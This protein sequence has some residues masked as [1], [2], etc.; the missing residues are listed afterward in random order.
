MA[1][2]RI[3]DS[4]ANAGGTLQARADA[5]SFGA[6]VGRGLQRVG[7]GLQ[8]MEDRRQQELERAEVSD[9][10]SAGYQDDLN[11]EQLYEQEAQTAQPGDRAVGDRV[12]QKVKD[13]FSAKEDKYTT[14]RARDYAKQLADR[15]INQF[16][17]RG[18]GLQAALNG[19]KYKNDAVLTGD[20]VNQTVFANPDSY[21]STRDRL[22][23]EA[24][25]GLGFW[26]FAKPGDRP[27]VLES[28]T[29]SA[30]WNAGLGT[31]AKPGGVQQF[32]SKVAPGALE[33]KDWR[34]SLKTEKTGIPWFDDLDADKKIQ[35]ISKA[36]AD[37][38]QS[39]RLEAGNLKELRDNQLSELKLYGT[40]RSPLSRAQFNVYG[41]KADEEWRAYRGNLKSY[42]LAFDLVKLPRAEALARIESLKPR[43][44]DVNP[45]NLR[46]Y[47]MVGQAY[48]DLYEQL[49][50][51]QIGTAQA[52]QVPGISPIS[53]GD[54]L[55]THLQKLSLRAPAVR[56]LAANNGK[57]AWYSN[58]EADVMRQKLAGI[59]DNEIRQHFQAVRQIIKD[60]TEHRADPTQ[61][62]PNNP[63]MAASALLAGKN[64]ISTIDNGQVYDASLVSAR[65]MSGARYLDKKSEE[66]K[67]IRDSGLPDEDKMKKRFM[68]SV[69]DAV[70]PEYMDSA[71]AIAKA[72]YIGEGLA[73]RQGLS[74]G[75]IDQT[76]ME[77]A[78]NLTL[79]QISQNPDGTKVFAPW[80]M[81]PARFRNE[82][83][84]R[85]DAL[86]A[87][88][89]V[90]GGFDS[91]SLVP[92]PGREGVYGI[93]AGSSILPVVIDLNQPVAK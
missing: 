59:G 28:M 35:L 32:L 91:Q 42:G 38:Q 67:S 54:D 60:P 52:R 24:Q 80:G 9:A 6:D 84:M 37:Y 1:Q 44:G 20:A 14:P 61:L 71:Y 46:Q 3:Y 19:Q 53:S 50:R 8:R 11:L 57:T 47:Q 74:G 12:L 2:I 85:Y 76:Q 33:G 36:D 55:Q 90:T 48:S 30:A 73:T 69:G 49:S 86:K 72:Y 17:V 26:A 39:R 10:A 15:A 68:A 45:D 5:E 13:Y 29:E 87:A 81:D 23:S 4:Q 63:A 62:Y 31:L 7:Q 93:K 88:G 18:L 78:I 70:P 66:G 16:G 64:G 58:L 43:P 65:V 92:L 34:G 27:Q 89:K 40:V 83:K 82:A 51:D 22:S 79:G 21:A 41:D 25:N 77:R 75:A 56:D